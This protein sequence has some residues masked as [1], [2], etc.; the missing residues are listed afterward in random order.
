[1]TFAFLPALGSRNSA[2]FSAAFLRVVGSAVASWTTPNKASSARGFQSRM[3]GTTAGVATAI[4]VSAGSF[5][6]L[7]SLKRNARCD[8]AGW[9]NPIE[10]ILSLKIVRLFGVPRFRPP[11]RSPGLEPRSMFHSPGSPA[12]L[13][14]WVAHAQ[15]RR[16]RAAPHRFPTSVSSC[17]LIANN[18]LLPPLSIRNSIATRALPEASSTLKLR[19]RAKSS[20]QKA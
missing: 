13:R 15:D 10:R 3:A 9:S 17:Q 19:R 2:I 7:T 6:S 12:A 16:E 1:M 8:A 11:R 18:S 4:R 20:Y 14:A 5:R